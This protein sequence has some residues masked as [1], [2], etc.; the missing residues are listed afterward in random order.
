MKKIQTCFDMAYCET[1]DK[2]SIS[3]HP[4]GWM[5]LLSTG[6]P[7]QQPSSHPH[8]FGLVN[9]FPPLNFLFSLLLTISEAVELGEW[10]LKMQ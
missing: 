10:S 1:K 4:S 7:E 9:K 2:G 3:L 5:E 8:M 6:G